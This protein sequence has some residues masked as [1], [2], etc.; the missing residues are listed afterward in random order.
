[1]SA[2]ATATVAGPDRFQRNIRL[3]YLYQ[4]FTNLTLFMPVWIVF[5]RTERHLT[6]TQVTAIMGGAWLITA[7]AEVPTGAIADTLG[8]R[9][10][11]MLGTILVAGGMVLVAV[12]ESFWVILPAYFVWS[13]GMA[14]QSGSDVALLY[15]SLQLSGREKDYPAVAGRSFAVIQLSQAV[16]SILGGL[17]AA[18]ALYLPMLVT[19]VL[20]ALALIFVARLREPQ[21]HEEARPSYLGTL[22]EAATL[23]RRR[24]NLRYL[25][26]FTSTLAVVPWLVVFVT[27]QP[28]LSDRRIAVAWFGLLFLVLRLASVI[29][30]RFGSR[31]VEPRLAGRYL[32][33]APIVF[34]A[35]L[36]IIAV[37]RTW[38]VGFAMMAVIGFLQGTIRPSL[39]DLLNQRATRAVRA[40]LLS[41][42]S[43]IYTLLIAAS[44]PV[45]GVVTD[46]WSIGSAYLVFAAFCAVA[47]LLVLL[48]LRSER[49]DGAATATTA[50]AV[51]E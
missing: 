21:Q 15:E 24:A 50:D 22:R 38:W 6:L 27:F 25:I 48:W 17:L 12:V 42:Q 26:L 51:P 43:L 39:S 46:R 32:L 4:C 40:T 11:L 47:L 44:Q 29:G 34:A 5:L 31:A 10:S 35:A 33:A 1:V 36:V 19:S 18:V 13:V 16:S 20:T 28:Y 14:L 49:R 9:F 8:R 7:L 41:L 23:V 37:V 45:F 3:V 2:E 30:S